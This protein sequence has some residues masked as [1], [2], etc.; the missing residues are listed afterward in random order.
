[1]Y[2][3]RQN[4]RIEHDTAL[5]KQITASLQDNTKLY[6]KFTEDPDFQNWLSGVAFAVMYTKP[7]DPQ[8]D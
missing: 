3:D 1:M 6:K 7:N 4:A 2:S 8:E 5:K